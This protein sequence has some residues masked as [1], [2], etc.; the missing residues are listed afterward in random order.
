MSS[1]T[2]DVVE[3]ILTTPVH[4]AQISMA[5]DDPYRIAMHSASTSALP[6]APAAQGSSSSTELP[7]S[8]TQLSLHQVL[9]R[10]A[11]RFAHRATTRMSVHTCRTL[12][13][14][15]LDEID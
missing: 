2:F 10:V 15:L 12:N 3:D 7:G 8:S 1:H 9:A 4:P 13:N 5:P 6:A 11:P 14:T